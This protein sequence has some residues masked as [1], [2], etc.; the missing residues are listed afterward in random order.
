MNKFTFLKTF[1]LISFGVLQFSTLG[2]SSTKIADELIQFNKVNEISSVNCPLADQLTILKNP[3]YAT[4]IVSD[5][6]ANSEAFADLL[7][8]DENFQSADS[9][10]QITLF[11]EG[12]KNHLDLIGAGPINSNQNLDVAV[13]YG[14][15]VFYLQQI[16]T[17]DITP[18]SGNNGYSKL[19]LSLNN[20]SKNQDRCVVDGQIVNSMPFNN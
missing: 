1:A 9:T 5:D 12:I 20:L 4:I 6:A 8:S 18:M 14:S 13:T 7:L 2:F 16:A 17:D 19:Y 15:T 10:P 3:L 11:N